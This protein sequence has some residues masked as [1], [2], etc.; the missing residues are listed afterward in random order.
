[1]NWQL[2]PF[3]KGL[4]ENIASVDWKQDLRTLEKDLEPEYI[5]LSYDEKT[6]YVVLQAGFLNLR[7]TS[8]GA[9]V[10]GFLSGHDN[11]CP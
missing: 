10:H 2:S 9:C 7:D 3:S 4:Y 1:M 8:H 6:A 5:A 11:C